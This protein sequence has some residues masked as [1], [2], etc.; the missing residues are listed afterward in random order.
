MTE[1]YLRLPGASADLVAAAKRIRA[2]LIPALGELTQPYAIEAANAAGRKDE[3][4]AL[5]DDLKIFPMAN[6]GTLFDVAKKFLAKGEELGSLLSDRA[7]SPKAVRTG[8]GQIRSKTLGLLSRL[9]TDLQEEVAKNPK[10]PRDL[11]QRVFGYF[12][13][14]SEM[15]ASP[16]PAAAPAAPAAPAAGDKATDK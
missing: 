5:K 9:R 10:L 13:T 8:A 11:E 16:A 7:D 2:G 1:V 4:T 12:D 14:L 15:Q 6:G 3:L